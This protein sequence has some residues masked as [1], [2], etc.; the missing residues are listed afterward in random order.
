MPNTTV[1][2]SEF[3]AGMY[4]LETLSS[5]MYNDPLTIYREYVQNSVDSIDLVDR[6]KSLSV[7]IDLDLPNRKLTFSDNGAGIPSKDALKVLSA[8]GSSNKIDKG[9][10]GFRG[11]GR[12]GGLAFCEKATFRTKAYEETVESVQEW[13][14]N[15]LRRMLSENDQSAGTLKR[16][17]D[18]STTF[19]RTNSKREKD[20]YF[21]VELEGVSS[22]RNYI[23]DLK[24]VHD[25]LA[26]IAPVPFNPD[27]F[28]YGSEITAYLNRK[29]DNFST[30][31]I[32][33]N[34]HQVYKPYQDL[35]AV[36]KKSHDKVHGIEFFHL[37]KDDELIAAGWYGQREELRGAI[38][39]GDKT[40]GLRV[41]L[42]NIL[43]GDEHLLDDCFRE[44]RFNSYFIGE[45][46]INS[47][48]LVPN[49]RRD[50][51]VDNEYKTHFYNSV[52]EKLGLPLSKE[53]RSRSRLY[54]EKRKVSSVP[55]SI[56]LDHV[57][58][59]DL[60]DPVQDERTHELAC[61]ENPGKSDLSKD[62][63]T[64]KGKNDR[65]D[66]DMIPLSELRRHMEKDCKDCPNVKR[67]LD[68]LI[69]W[70]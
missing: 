55:K 15:R 5:G 9:M 19:Y 56:P 62:K 38:S 1:N 69:S 35:I 70:G 23:F 10:R 27:E 41:R 20:S 26:K 43:I 17:F 49:S 8:I 28:S 59:G 52:A 57:K 29:L 54:S 63:V 18:K 3:K 13:D 64:R 47:K 37:H 68:S 21:R 12:L 44:V 45:I 50:D 39:K 42:G 11:I 58:E 32:F 66:T 34:G 4:L 65:S 51:F 61:L 40:S 67:L 6:R 33:L 53:I 2:K 22:F 25:Y 24:R 60:P 16:L 14:C 48:H 36:T 46:H 7:K 31:N 30:Y